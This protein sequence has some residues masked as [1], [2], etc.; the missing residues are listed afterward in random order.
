MEDLPGFCSVSLMMDRETTAGGQ[1]AV[2]YD[3]RADMVAANEQ[4]TAL[5]KEFIRSVGMEITEMV[6]FDLVLAHL[7]VPEM[8]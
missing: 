5:R 4:A 3:S 1:S 2:T 8:V 7:R 6:E